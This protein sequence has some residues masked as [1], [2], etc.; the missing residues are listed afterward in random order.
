MGEK[1][2]MIAELRGLNAVVMRPMGLVHQEAKKRARAELEGLL[3]F[4]F[5]EPSE[6]ERRQVQLRVDDEY[7]AGIDLSH[8]EYGYHVDAVEDF[9][10]QDFTSGEVIVEINDRP[11]TGLT[12]EE[13]EN[14]FGECFSNGA[15]LIII[16]M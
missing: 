4:Y 5:Q 2:R 1:F 14:T 13:I 9:P 11:L 16:K 10:G 7:G 15:S 3:G 6:P 12:E 8:T